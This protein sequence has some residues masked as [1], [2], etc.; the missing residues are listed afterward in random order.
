VPQELAEPD[1]ITVYW[2][3]QDRATGQHDFEGSAGP[4][5]FD[6]DLHRHE[7]GR[8]RDWGGR[9]VTAQQLAPAGVEGGFGAA[10]LRTEGADAQAVALPAGQELSVPFFAGIAEMGSR[11]GGLP[12]RDRGSPRR[13]LNGQVKMGLAER[14]RNQRSELRAWARKFAR[15][16]I[17]SLR[18]EFGG[19][20]VSAALKQ[21]QTN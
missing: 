8:R 16:C 17:G 1:G 6:H 19:R 13:E 3:T 12:N 9:V 20:R 5:R 15:R 2:Q 11:H 14:I 7:G 18:A 10:G 4:G 21:A